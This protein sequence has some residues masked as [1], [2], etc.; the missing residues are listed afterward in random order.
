M[1]FRLLKGVTTVTQSPASDTGPV[2]RLR[3]DAARNVERISAAAMDVFAERGLDVSM[4]DVAE[5]A[6]VGVGTVYRRFG[7]KTGLID[8]LFATKVNEVIAMVDLVATSPDSTEAFVAHLVEL[9]DFLANNKGLR[10]IMLHN[11]ARPSGS[12]LAALERLLPRTDRLIQKLHETGWLRQ[13][14]SASDL[15]LL[16][17]A[18]G[19]A[20]DFGG[21]EHPDLWRRILW[22]L[23]DGMRADSRQESNIRVPPA[24]PAPS[25]GLWK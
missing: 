10:Q 15:P 2:N 7:D 8:S 14:F 25:A 19:A 4:A 16:M 17:A 24:L 12:H 3:S 5:R 11:G 13:N 23:I 6:G 9:S 20:H 22:L 21:T 18:I 1:S